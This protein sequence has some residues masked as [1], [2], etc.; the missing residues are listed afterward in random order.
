MLLSWLEANMYIYKNFSCE[1]SK[2]DILYQVVQSGCLH[3][4][5]QLDP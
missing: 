4:T 2:P 3:S 5:T 1:V